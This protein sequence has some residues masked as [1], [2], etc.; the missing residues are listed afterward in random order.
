M[1]NVLSTRTLAVSATLILLGCSGGGE[2]GNTFV[3]PTAPVA[4]S[5]EVQGNAQ[6]V[7]IGQVVSSAPV[8]IVKDQSG[9]AMSGI[10]VTFVISSGAGTLS[11]TS[12]TTNASGA[13]TLPTWT[14]GTTPGANA[15]TVTAVGGSNPTAQITATARPPR[16]TLL[17]YMAADN[18]LALSGIGDIEE[19]EM[20]GANP[21]VQV[22]VQAEFN[23]AA[24]AE[25]GGT[26]ADVHLPNFN[27]VRF[28]FGGLTSLAPNVL[29]PNGAVTDI[30]NRAMTDPAQLR[31]FITWGKQTYPAERYAVFLWN[32]GGGYSGLL[33]DETSTPGRL[34]SLPEL[35]TALSTVGTL[36]LI[37]FDMC[38]MAGYETLVAVNGI[39]KFA[40]FSQ[41]IEP[42]EGDD[43]THA[44]QAL[45]NNPAMDG[46]A[47]ATVIVDTYDASYLN[48]A[49]STTKSAYD[50]TGLPAFETALATAA[51][52]LTASIGSLAPTI[53]VSAQKSQKYTYPMFTDISD[54]MDSLSVSVTDA[55]LKTQ[56]A[57][58]RTQ[59]RATGFRISSR[60]RNGSG[61]SA[62]SVTKSTG[63]SIVMP[64]GFGDDWFRETGNPLSLNAYQTAMPGK[65]WTQF[66]T[67]YSAQITPPAAS[68]V[69]LGVNRWELYLVWDSAAVSRHADLD[70]WVIEPNGSLYIPF[71]GTVTANG[72]LSSDSEQDHTYYEG[73][74]M[75]RYVQIGTYY[76]YANLYADPQ[77]YRPQ[78][79]VE[80]RQ[81]AAAS[82]VSLYNPTFP[83]MSKLTSWLNDPT[84]TFA[85]ADA[86]NYTDL[87]FSAYLDIT[88]GSG[89]DLSPTSN[90]LARSS[91]GV[92]SA[93]R[94]PLRLSAANPSTTIHVQRNAG[95]GIGAAAP[96]MTSAQLK[97]IRSNWTARQNKRRAAIS[98]RP[99][100]A[101]PQLPASALRFAPSARLL[102]PPTR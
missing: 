26:P 77:D 75:N 22:V 23:P 88:A 21:E 17:V 12:A 1:K 93:P 65:P 54:F 25:A 67:A 32:H 7:R 98:S 19:M 28:A 63:L 43:Y 16:W 64:S 96:T 31:E 90:L 2:G 36:D 4:S 49:S 42:G 45:Y 76:F 78:F 29:G 60:A 84:P 92:T 38:L 50:L 61:Y 97:T 48:A 55:T 11:G 66:L 30:G 15:V 10:A 68:Y 47:L 70:F 8:V 13:A 56:L 3:A 9:V 52:T 83:R 74:L 44:L 53:G 24:F 6:T 86:G 91:R 99:T 89:L 14:L 73:Y 101:L 39:A 37:D 82:L 80:Y 102:S 100:F 46:R 72:A 59:A 69:D 79:D 41:E 18:N 71:L 20:A 35:K 40:T 95:S 51:Q 34:M 57:A 62:N 33:S 87:A 58:V 27:T 85:E 94:G 5:I 81:G